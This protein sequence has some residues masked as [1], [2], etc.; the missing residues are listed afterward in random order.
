MTL[1][2]LFKSQGYA[3]AHAGKWHLGMKEQ[4]WPTLQGFDEYHVGVIETSDGTLYRESMKR[5]GMPDSFIEKGL[6]LQRRTS[7]NDTV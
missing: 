7:N 1:A 3:T 6:N 5:S 2:E 4:S